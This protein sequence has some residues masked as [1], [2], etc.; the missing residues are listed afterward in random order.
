MVT[1]SSRHAGSGVVVFRDCEILSARPEAS[2]GDGE[3][4]RHALA[5]RVLGKFDAETEIGST[6]RGHSALFC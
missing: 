2:C 1:R 4:P 3:D 5:G 6:L